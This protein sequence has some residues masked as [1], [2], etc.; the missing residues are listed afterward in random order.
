MFTPGFTAG[1]KHFSNILRNLLV[2]AHTEEETMVYILKTPSPAGILT[3]SSDGESITGLWME[4]QKYYGS[5]LD[6]KLLTE[7]G[8]GRM[9]L[10]ESPQLRGITEAGENIP[11]LAEALRWLEKYFAGEDPGNP[12][13]LAPAGSEFRQM[14]WNILLEI[15]RGETT[16]Y[17]AI[18]R[19]LA[20]RRGLVSMSSQA[21]GGAVGHNPISIM[22]PCHRVLGADG[23]LTGYAAGIEVKKMLLSLESKGRSQP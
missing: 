11:V 13:S 15:S 4:G 22:I 1:R 20:A 5:T 9:A 8:Q 7:N 10:K 6:K 23:S 14:V 2:C 19:E 21:V 3:L 18:A 12:P 17:G 16:T